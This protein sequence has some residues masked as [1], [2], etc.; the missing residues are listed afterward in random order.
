MDYL[1]DQE[2]LNK[3]NQHKHRE[4]YVKII[5]LTFSEEPV[6]LIEG[7]ATQ[8]SI[9][10]DGSSIIRRTCSLTLVAKELNINEFYW[11]IKSKF[12]L[13]IGL[14]N[15][16]DSKYP[17]IIWFPQG[18]YAIT[19][20]NTTYNT[21]NYT[22]S[23]S[24][25]DKMCFLNG[26]FGGN[27]TASIDFG[28]QEFYDKLTNTTTFTPVPIKTIIRESVHTYGLEPYSNIIINDLDEAAVELLE[29]RGD[30]PLY[31]LYDVKKGQFTNYTINSDVKISFADG[32]KGP[33]SI[34]ELK[35]Y[36]GAYDSRVQLV[37]EFP[38][39]AV[40]FAADGAGTV[41]TIAK[42]EYGQTVGYRES[43]LIYAGELISS[44]GESLTSILDKIKNMLG[45]YEYFYNLE[46]R[47]VFQRKKNYIQKTWN[48]IVK[49]G[50]DKYAD[51]S[52]Y[53]SAF[54]YKFDDSSLITSFQNSPDLSNLKNDYSIWGQR[55][56]VSGEKIPIHY[57]YAI[58]V[59]P[60]RY[61]SINVVEEDLQG[62]DITKTQESTT[63]TIE[64]VDWREIIYQMA[65]DYYQYGQ[66]D[67]FLSKIIQANGDLYPTGITGYEQYYIDL[68]GFWRQLYNTN[69]EGNYDSFID[70]NETFQP[71]IAPD[72]EELI[73]L[74]IK[75]H[76]ESVDPTKKIDDKEKILA[77]RYISYTHQDQDNQ[78]VEEISRWELIPWLDAIEI[79]YDGSFNGKESNTFY[80]VGPNKEYHK[81]ATSTKD[82]YQ[83]SDLFVY[84]EG[85]YK[86]I[87][88]SSYALG[89]QMNLYRFVDDGIYYSVFEIPAELKELYLSSNH[90]NKYLYQSRYDI[91]G[92]PIASAL[93][94]KYKIDYYNKYYN[95]IMD[96]KSDNLYW[97]NDIINNPAG[98]NFWFDFLDA[99][100]NELSQFSVKAVGDRTKVVNDNDV[101]AIYFRQIPNL[102]FT[103]MAQYNK[104]NFDYSEGYIPVFISK[105]LESL[106]TISS[107]GKSAQD[108][109]NEL[110]YNHSYCIE[111]ITIQSIPIYYLSPN[112]RIFVR[113]DQSKI[114]GEYIISKMTIPL[115][116]NG[117]MSITATKAPERIK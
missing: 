68:Q 47:F 53:T 106:F 70:E 55:T 6:E 29:Y 108:K 60:Q 54:I 72:S 116:Y 96:E 12:K 97:T 11:G 82:R 48:N 69:P 42:V 65:L 19:T 43:E 8:G 34:S 102:I 40:V 84:E 20:F 13:E 91:N 23:I 25:K 85:E 89:S 92:N 94:V 93:S 45:E 56:T 99:E 77:L 71:T 28:T 33:F 9:S 117:I 35:D 27:L 101:S 115:A 51:S 79:D 52:A 31:L 15:N 5:A 3:L 32:T 87:L 86:H 59:K 21:S 38:A 24:G 78:N 36:G 66:L 58:D 112:T 16:I 49:I 98:L 17:D 63:Y 61:T 110:L 90:Y 80:V 64:D 50:E 46:G 111:N 39:T 113:D 76:Y 10:I 95:Y 107:Q 18:I 2:F 73:E 30:V 88:D 1:T 62:T 114:N 103:T 26:D 4:T 105:N 41:Y 37:E 44:I 83:K 109:L 14:K 67:S 7:M 75:G 57:R 22:I 74:Y 100:N 81:I 104:S